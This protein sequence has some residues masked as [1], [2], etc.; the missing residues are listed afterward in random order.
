[1]KNL[2]YIIFSNQILFLIILILLRIFIK[3]KSIHLIN[4]I[5]IFSIY[6][7]LYNI[8]ASYFKTYDFVS[9]TKIY[10]SNSVIFLVI[11]STLERS[12]ALGL[13][14]K[15]FLKKIIS[16]KALE[17]SFNINKLINKRIENLVKNNIVK[18]AYNKIVLTKNGKLLYSII[19]I[20][21]KIF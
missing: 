21:K 5:M 7:P 8:Y 11:I 13:I 2:I 20:S 15:I 6:I 14:R 18:T 10:F 9:I 1:M 4:L 3:R 19:L 12:V 17:K 16:K